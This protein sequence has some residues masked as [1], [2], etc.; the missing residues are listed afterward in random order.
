MDNSR[1]VSGNW[2]KKKSSFH[3]VGMSNEKLASLAWYDKTLNGS[4]TFSL[5]RGPRIPKK[6]DPRVLKL[7][8]WRLA[9]QYLRIFLP[10]NGSNL[11]NFCINS[12]LQSCLEKSHEFLSSK[13]SILE[14]SRRDEACV[15]GILQAVQILASPSAKTRTLLM[16]FPPSNSRD[17]GERA[18]FALER[19]KA[20][21]T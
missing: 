11:K 13:K 15:V 2:E 20:I 19:R 3:R 6:E 9:K 14:F 4:L 18:H 21:K 12:I 8:L 7:P 16:F 10:W 17:G 1:I 5:W